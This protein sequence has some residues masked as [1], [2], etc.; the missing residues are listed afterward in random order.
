MLHAYCSPYQHLTT[1]LPLKK[2]KNVFFNCGHLNQIYAI[3]FLHDDN[4]WCI[5]HANMPI[6]LNAV[7]QHRQY[8]T[9][10][11]PDI[12]AFL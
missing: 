5:L 1:I 9:G 4:N 11:T 12:S 6:T 8:L 2:L 3:L 10:E 7:F